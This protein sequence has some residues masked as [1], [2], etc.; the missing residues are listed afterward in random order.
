MTTRII[1][2][3]HTLR[4][5]PNGTVIRDGDGDVCER[6]GGWCP[7]GSETIA[8]HS[9]IVLPATV[10]WDPVT[11]TGEQTVADRMADMDT[12]EQLRFI[13]N[14]VEVA[15]T[16]ITGEHSDERQTAHR[17]ATDLRRLGDRL[18]LAIE[19]RAEIAALND[20]IAK[21]DRDGGAIEHGSLGTFL[22]ER[23]WTHHEPE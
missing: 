15:A 3:T 21:F 16:N 17:I 4:N 6:D 23:G 1:N 20:D 2:N 7:V 11:G 19:H 22:V 12:P 8:A 14:S 10:L 18:Q 13:G 5:L 9:E